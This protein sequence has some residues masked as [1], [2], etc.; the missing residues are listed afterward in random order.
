MRLSTETFE[1]NLFMALFFGQAELALLKF[2]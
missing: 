2:W 1:V